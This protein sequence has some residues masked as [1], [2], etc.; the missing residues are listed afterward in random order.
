MLD[1]DRWSRNEP[2]SPWK[3]AYGVFA[4]ALLVAT[5]WSLGRS[6][7]PVPFPAIPA[8]GPADASKAAAHKQ[9]KAPAISGRRLTERMMAEARSKNLHFEEEA[10]GISLDA[11]RTYN[12]KRGDLPDMDTGLGYLGSIP[13]EFAAP[14]GVRVVT[15]EAPARAHPGT[16]FVNAFLTV[17]VLAGSNEDTCSR[18]APELGQGPASLA[19]VIGGVVFSG[20]P[21]SEAANM[22]EYFGKYYHGYLEGSCYEI[23]YGVVTAKSGTVAGLKPVDTDAV[24]RRLEKIADT[25]SVA[26]PDVKDTAI[27]GEKN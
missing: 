27:V 19:Q 21:N 5:S 2:R 11:P 8:P 16:D 22:H 1:L 18:F 3:V 25:I 6:R 24:L 14:G 7:P 15:L 23:G 4:C 17:S 26:P 10:Y 9:K 20:I 13:M 12:M